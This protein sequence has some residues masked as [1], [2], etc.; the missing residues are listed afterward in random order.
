MRACKRMEGLG[1]VESID[2]LLA[3]G[4][5]KGVALVFGQVMLWIAD[6]ASGGTKD[7]VAPKRGLHKHSFA[8][9]GVRS[10]ENCAGGQ[11]LSALG[12]PFKQQVSG[13]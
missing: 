2:Q 7:E 8:E 10:G 12:R 1:C 13:P 5:N 9:F 11:W 6:I 3:L 4:Q